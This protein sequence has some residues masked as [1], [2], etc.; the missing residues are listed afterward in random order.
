MLEIFWYAFHAVAPIMPLMVFGYI[1]RRR[2]YFDTDTLKKLN[3]F[4]FR[5][6]MCALMFCN[7]YALPDISAISKDTI[8]AVFVS[9]VAITAAGFVLAFAVTRQHNRRGVIIQASFRS[10]FA[11]IG[12]ILATNL[13]GAE[14]AAAAASIQAP[15]IFYYNIM[16]VICLT[17]FSDRE[18]RSVDF[19]AVGKEIITNPL[20][21]GIMTGLLCLIA[22]PLIPRTAD[23]E[24][25][26]SIERDLDF[27]YSCVKNLADMTT[28]LVLI[29][30]GAQIDFSA[31]EGMKKELIACVAMR[32]VGAPA[33]GFG[34]A[35]ALRSIGWI[36]L[37]PAMV[38]AL[39]GFWG[40]PMAIAGAIMAEEMGGD[41]EL[42][43]QAAVW[44][45]ALSLFTLFLWILVARAFG[46]L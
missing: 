39:L 6:T 8:L 32:L 9:I 21:I 11:V 36:S 15:G 41:G 46:L 2:G 18:D 42:A 10:N 24:L 13:C 14:G 1:I 27:L 30:L 22:R 5:F 34:T 16:A 26:F 45:S 28:P 20:I 40:T 23:G 37:T 29:T 12:L 43:R 7:I 3:R 35:L 25:I 44:T 38:S 19:A 17:L 33:I 4:S 31:M